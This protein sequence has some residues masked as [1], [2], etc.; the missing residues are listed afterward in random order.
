MKEKLSLLEKIAGWVALNLLP[1]NL[2]LYSN[3]LGKWYDRNG[4]YRF[5]IGSKIILKDPRIFGYDPNEVLEV[6]GHNEEGGYLTT[7]SEE[8]SHSKW[9][10]EHC[11]RLAQ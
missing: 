2:T 4:F 9:N 5:Q 7:N 10:I 6:K 11:F 8:R 1:E 3:R